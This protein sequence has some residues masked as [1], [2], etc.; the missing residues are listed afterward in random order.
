MQDASE[1]VVD[2]VFGKV[3]DTEE[4]L[5]MLFERVPLLAAASTE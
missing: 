4:V 5:A 3:K 1:R 2:E